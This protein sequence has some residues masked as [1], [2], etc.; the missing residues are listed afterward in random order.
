MNQQ[1]I[2]RIKIFINGERLTVVATDDGSG[3]Q[4]F[5]DSGQTLAVF[6]DGEQRW[7]ASVDDSNYF[8]G[9]LADTF[10]VDGLAL[11]P[12]GTFGENKN[13]VWI[14][15]A[16]SVSDFGNHGF[17]LQYKNTSVGSGSSSV[18]GADTSGK[19][20][21]FTSSG[22]A[23]H[24]CAMPDCPENNWCSLLGE[25]YKQSSSAISEG[26]NPVLTGGGNSARTSV[27]LQ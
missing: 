15:K 1:K 8:T 19:D 16:P 27:I 12:T 5:A 9:Y 20:N 4:D 14:P 23:T 25:D 21:H 11:E 24:D 10:G 13:G 26:V 3:S 2:D 17:R 18:I 7:G 22:T 6:Q